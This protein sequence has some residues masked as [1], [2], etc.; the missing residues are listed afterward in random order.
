LNCT[1]KLGHELIEEMQFFM[2]KYNNAFKE[3]L[4]RCCAK[5]G[6]GL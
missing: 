6:G 3:W 1:L 4:S 2:T 5:R